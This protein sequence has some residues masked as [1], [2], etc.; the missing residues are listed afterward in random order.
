MLLLLLNS[1]DVV[2]SLGTDSATADGAIPWGTSAAGAGTLLDQL[3]TVA[4]GGTLPSGAGLGA[5]SALGKLLFGSNADGTS[6]GI[7]G[8]LGANQ[9]GLLSSL[10]P[11]FLGAYGANQQA[12]AYRDVANKYLAMGEPYRNMLLGSYSPNFSA[13]SIPGFNDAINQSSN[14]ILRGLSTQG[15][16]YDNPGGLQEATKYVTSNVALPALNTYRSQLGSFGQ[17]GTNTAGTA[18]M[19]SAGS[20]GGVLNAI[21][22]GLNGVLN[23]QQ[24]DLSSALKTLGGLKLNTGFSLV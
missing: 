21:G 15:N 16:P 7:L 10:L 18:D 12:N 5:A 17:L 4:S 23:P 9:N 1:S 6:R 22:Y 3:G 2:Q 14:A 13:S 24:N 20:K 8:M 19:T 11:A